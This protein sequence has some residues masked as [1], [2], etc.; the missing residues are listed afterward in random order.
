MNDLAIIL[1][2]TEGG[3]QAVAQAGNFELVPD[4]AHEF[5]TLTTRSSPG[6]AKAGFI[7]VED[8]G[9]VAIGRYRG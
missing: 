8:S 7:R 2:G 6:Y 1:A 3:L 9:W 5:S 4:T